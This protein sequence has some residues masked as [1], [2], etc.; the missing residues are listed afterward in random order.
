MINVNLICQNIK[1][2]YQIDLKITRKKPVTIGLHF[3]LI[4]SATKKALKYE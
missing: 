3:V 2:A 1:E 4:E